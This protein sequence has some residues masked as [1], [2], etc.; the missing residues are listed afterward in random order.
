MSDR[1]NGAS[2][3]KFRQ[4]LLDLLFRL[5]IE[6]RRGFVEQED[7]RVLQSSACNSEAW[8]M[9]TGKKAAFVANHRVVLL[10]LSHDELVRVSCVCGFVNLFLRRLQL[11]E[12]NVVKDRVVKQK[13][14]LSDEP[15]VIAQR[16]LRYQAQVTAVDL[17]RAGSRIV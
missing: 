2:R 14:L 7:R 3:S 8:L 9:A 15:D 13:R 11:S 16:F 5:R 10:W 17:Y 1:D 6:R 12:L 4:S